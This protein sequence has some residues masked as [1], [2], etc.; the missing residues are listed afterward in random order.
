MTPAAPRIG[1]V[2]AVS[3]AM[4]PVH[5]AFARLWP[6]A[7][8]TNLFDGSLPGELE[9]AGAITPA[10]AGRIMSLAQLAAQDAQGV[11]FTCSAFAPAIEAA[12]AALPLPVLKPDEA[13]FDTALAAGSRIGMLATFA[14]SVPS[15]EA[16]F[17][18][19]AAQL[20][21]HARIE[22]VLVAG[23]W[24]ALGSGDLAR[25]DDLVAQAAARLQHTDAIML[26]Q[27]S[28]STAL[29]KAQ[30]LSK[31]AVLGA[32]ETAVRRMMARLAP[33]Q[34]LSALR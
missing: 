3:A 1:L 12:A 17:M 18:R 19:R 20:G 34:P 4:A 28:T 27:F 7:Q 8:I 14:P 5:A 11:L 31:V 24:E 13:M 32:P 22:S 33:D 16:A 6:E 29:P 25:H 30:A 23:A 2:H 9:R 21:Q 10:I 26:A 15:M